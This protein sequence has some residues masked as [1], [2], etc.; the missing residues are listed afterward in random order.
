MADPEVTVEAIPE[1][2]SALEVTEVK[3]DQA[4]WLPHI[5]NCAKAGIT[6]TKYCRENNLSNTQFSYW[7][8][9]YR[10]QSSD[11]IGVKISKKNITGCLCTLELPNGRRLLIHDIE[12][13]R[14]LPQILGLTK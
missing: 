12:C 2:N 1:P 8:S 13:L 5:E 6:A 9:K 14:L 11:F 3:K 7:R 10:K 4:Y